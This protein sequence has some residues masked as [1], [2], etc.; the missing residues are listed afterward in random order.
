MKRRFTINVTKGYIV[1][2]VI[3]ILGV[4]MLFLGFLDYLEFK[5]EQNAL[6]ISELEESQIKEGQ[7]VKGVIREIAGYYEYPENESS[8]C[9]SPN[10]A[11][12]PGNGIF[13]CLYTIK[14]ANG[15]YINIYVNDEDWELNKQLLGYAKGKG[16]SAYFEGK[17]VKEYGDEVKDS[18][19][20]KLFG[21]ESREEIDKLIV[22]DYIIFQDSFE[23]DTKK[24]TVG[25][26]LIVVSIFYFFFSGGVKG[27]LVYW[28]EEEEN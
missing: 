5:K 4:L 26:L 16:N 12:N 3:F 19:H 20:Q 1:T 14:I 28:D 11:Y 13:Y 22:S 17:I 24:F 6:S 27:L 10:E 15:K 21:V 2:A 25:F 8:F 7:Y 18:W 9:I 23:V